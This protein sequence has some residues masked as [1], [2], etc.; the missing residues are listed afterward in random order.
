MEKRNGLRYVFRITVGISMLVYLLGGAS[1][2]TTHTVCASGCDFS[3]IQAAINA[4]ND[5]ETIYVRS[6][7]YHENIIVN[8]YLTIKGENKENTIIEGDGINDVI[9]IELGGVIQGFKITGGKYGITQLSD[10]WGLSVDCKIEGNEIYANNIGIM[11]GNCLGGSIIRNNI[12]DNTADGILITSHGMR[13]SENRLENNGGNGITMFDSGNTI[14]HNYIADSGVNGIEMGFGVSTVNDNTVKRSKKYGILVETDQNLI[15]NN[16]FENDINEIV[17]PSGIVEGPLE[18]VVWDKIS[19]GPNI[20]GGPSIGGNFW[21][22]PEGN[23][24]SD[25][26]KDQDKDGFCDEKFGIYSEDIL[27]EFRDYSFTYDNLPLASNK[28]EIPIP[29][30]LPSQSYQ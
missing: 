12:H 6:G 2:T 3:S 22:N 30:F 17:K 7:T 20:I 24:F 23:G 29:E 1:A 8:K 14:D 27:L 13:I 28:G 5:G 16:I 10:P 19:P 4:A 21:S 18:T 15:Y 11:T 9:I 26:C 25:T